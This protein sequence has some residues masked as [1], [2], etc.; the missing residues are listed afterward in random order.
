MKHLN[1][2]FLF[3]LLL[4][5]CGSN[6]DDALSG[7]VNL[8]CSPENVDASP[9]G[10]SYV[11]NVCCSSSEWTAYANSDCSSWVSV[12]VDGS[13]ET[14]GTVTVT[15][16]ANT[17]SAVRSGSII[18]KSGTKTV[19]VPV[20]QDMPIQVSKNEIYSKST[21]ET[22][23]LDVISKA[24]WSVKSNNSWITVVKSTDNKTITVTT[25]VNSDKNERHGS[26]D[27]ISG[28]QKITVSVI[29]N[30]ADD[31]D[32][33]VPKGYNLVWHD[34]FGEGTSLGS[35]WTHEVQNS[36]WVNDELQNY[37]NGAINGKRVTEVDDGKLN[38]NCFKYNGKIYSGRVYAKVNSGWKYGY[39]ES[40]IKLPKGTGTWPAFWMMPANNNFSTNPWP[41]C[42]EIDIMEEVGYDPNRI[43][44]TIHCNK[45]NNGGTSNESGNL[46]V[47]TAEADYHVYA[48]KW[49]HNEMIFYVDGNVILTYKNDGSGVNAWPFDNPFYI[50]LNLA[51]GGSWGGQTWTG[52]QVVDESAL[53][54]TMSVDYVRVFQEK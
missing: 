41:G 35:D 8:S 13:L 26:L 49:T 36:G 46:Y 12:K 34:E 18:I 23:S 24:D 14:E 17:G 4:V 27:I 11:L 54:A 20:T 48:M 19:S 50:I 29:Q 15:V 3:I 33:I 10:G 52:K 37:V 28:D 53:P 1:I 21:G 7:D 31:R 51:W 5:S 2:L 42:G 30:S 38:I 16:N 32:V 43:H 9:T 40:R 25:E 47:T 44:S 39:I 22:F 45:Y 6:S